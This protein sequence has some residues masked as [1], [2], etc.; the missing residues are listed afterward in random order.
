MALDRRQDF[1][2]AQY[3]VN[4]FVDFDQIFY[5]HLYWQDVDLDDW[6]MFFSIIFNRV[7]ALAWC[8]NLVYAQYLVDQLMDFDKIL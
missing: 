7:M 5:M 3:L 6:T 2:Y 1:V 4:Y 8:W